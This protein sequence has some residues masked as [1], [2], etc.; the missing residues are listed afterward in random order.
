MSAKVLQHTGNSV[1]ITY[2]HK[3]NQQGSTGAIVIII[4]LVFILL[5]A[6]GFGGW[7]YMN[8]Q[9][10]KNNVDKKIAAA[11][12]VAQ[13]KTSSAKDNEFSEKEKQPLRTYKG[14]DTYG[15]VQIKYPKSWSAYVIQENGDEPLDAYFHPDVVPGV[16]SE[17][18]FA[19]RIQVVSSS[20]SEVLEEYENLLSNGSVKISAYRAP[21]VK[22][23][24][25]S[26]ID[27]EVATEKRGSMVILP[28]RDKTLKV[29]TESTQYVN[30]LNKNILPNL[31]FSP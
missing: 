24:L 4:V 1:N 23:T 26:R 8:M 16:G 21:K 6:L 27:G 25:G 17:P 2:M 9:D 20:Y 30:D 12:I 28:L 13:Q 3:L 29:W 22:G 10:Y 5:G 31:T 18:S 7:A 19:L 11:V 14:P 15:G